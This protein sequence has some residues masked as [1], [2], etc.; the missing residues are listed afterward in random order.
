M[1]KA[2]GCRRARNWFRLPGRRPWLPLLSLIVVLARTGC[3]MD[4]P[5]GPGEGPGHRAQQLALRPEQE[6]ALGEQAYLKVLR[7]SSRHVL[8]GD[9]PRVQRVRAIAKRIVRAAGSRPLRR[10]INLHLDRLHLVL[11]VIDRL[12]QL[13]ARAAYFRQACGTS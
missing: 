13:G 10:E 9:D 12:P 8:P 7:E 4:L 6:L 2:H 11:D 1:F 5:N 3:G